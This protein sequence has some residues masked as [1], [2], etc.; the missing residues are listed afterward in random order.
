MATVSRLAQQVSH[1]DQQHALG[2]HR[3][4]RITQ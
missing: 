1:L 4:H 3:W 2:N